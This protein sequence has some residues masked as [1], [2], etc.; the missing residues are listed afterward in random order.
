M[1]PCLVLVQARKTRPEITEKLLTGTLRIKSNKNKNLA[2]EERTGCF[3]LIALSLL[4]V[5]LCLSVNSGVRSSRCHGLVS[6]VAV[7]P[8]RT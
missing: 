5:C 6:V 7:L 4:C 8:A 1:Y 3:T 2:E